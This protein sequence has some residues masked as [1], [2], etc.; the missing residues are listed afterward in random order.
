MQVNC[1]IKGFCAHFSDKSNVTASPL[2]RKG[3]TAKQLQQNNQLMPMD[4]R[5]RVDIASAI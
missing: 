3:V 4:F 1:S 5:I 2:T